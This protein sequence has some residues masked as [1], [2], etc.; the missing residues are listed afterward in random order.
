MGMLKHL[1]FWPA[2]LPAYLTG[3]ALEKVEGMVRHELTDDG[4]IKEELLELQLQLELGEIDDAEFERR[5]AELMLWLR[6]VREWRDRLGMGVSGGIVRV[7]SG[8]DAEVD[9]EA[10]T[11]AGTSGRNA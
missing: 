3:F 1:L 10:D 4:K 11:G 6:E 8:A 2:T 9:P 7:A 5:E